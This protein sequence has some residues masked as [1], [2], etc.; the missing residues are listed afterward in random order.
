[1]YCTYQCVYTCSSSSVGICILLWLLGDGQCSSTC[2]T[3]YPECIMSKLQYKSR[4]GG[5]GGGIQQGWG[6]I[7][8]PPSPNTAQSSHITLVPYLIC[9]L[10]FLSDEH[11]LCL[12]G[13]S[14]L[15]ER[16]TRGT[17]PSH[18]LA[19]PG[20]TQHRV[21]KNILHLGF[22]INLQ[23]LHIMHTCMYMYMYM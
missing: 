17:G 22:I 20:Q 13:P 19:R 8:L 23:C 5:G 7:A 18:H 11:L 12:A 1:M 21:I 9:P 16:G 3:Y 6:A 4:G 14:L 2:H 10:V 15:W